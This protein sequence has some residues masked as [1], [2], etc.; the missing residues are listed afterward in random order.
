MARTPMRQKTARHTATILQL[1]RA[2]LR[3]AVASCAYQC[4]ARPN[5]GPQR[6]DMMMSDGVMSNL[7]MEYC[8][9]FPNPAHA[10]MVAMA[11]V[12]NAGMTAAGAIELRRT[13]SVKRAPA[14]GTL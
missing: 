5:S 11:E 4:P 14:N 12:H 8:G 13:S 7:G 6:T 2:L 1:R 3:I 9:T 10:T